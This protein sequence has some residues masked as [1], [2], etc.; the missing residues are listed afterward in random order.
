MVIGTP[1]PE[2]SDA[3]S[4]PSPFVTKSPE[5]ETLMKT[6]EGVPQHAVCRTDVDSP[7]AAPAP[8]SPCLRPVTRHLTGSGDTPTPGAHLLSSS[9]LLGLLVPFR[10]NRP[11]GW[12]ADADEDT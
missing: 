10:P 3:I 12:K 5:A 9:H 11:G 8:F 7:R 2:P 6:H 1:D 4:H